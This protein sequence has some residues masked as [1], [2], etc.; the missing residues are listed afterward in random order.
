LDFFAFLAFLALGA[1]DAS[2][3]AAA[4]AA[5]ADAEAGAS[6]ANAEAANRP[7]IRAAISFFI[8]RS[9]Y[10]NLEN[11]DSVESCPI[12]MRR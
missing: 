10:R 6:A 1:A 12:T 7:A 2:A 9:F 5:G 4:E 11:E 8:F 3:E